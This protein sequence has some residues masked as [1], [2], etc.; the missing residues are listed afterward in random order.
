MVLLFTSPRRSALAGTAAVEFRYGWLGYKLHITE[1]CDDPPPCTCRTA[2]PPG[3]GQPAAGGAAAG[4]GTAG[5]GARGYVT[6]T[7]S[8]AEL[9]DAVRR[10]AAGD[11]VFSPRLAG[12]V[13]DAFATGAP[14]EA[15]R[16]AFDPELDQLTSREWEVLR[17]IARG[18]TYASQTNKPL[19]RHRGRAGQHHDTPLEPTLYSETTPYQE[20]ARDLYISIKTV[21]THVSSVLR[22]LQLG[23]HPAA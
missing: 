21:E 20:I 6:K 12:F 14:A 9:V 2:G 13:L 4:G 1:P 22:K 23:W 16:P 17:L 7:I 10:V 18:Y 8:G 5:G 11:A 19:A 15:A 3:D